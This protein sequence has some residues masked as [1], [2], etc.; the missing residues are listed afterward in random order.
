MKINEIKIIKEESDISDLLKKLEKE[1]GTDYSAEIRKY[2][3]DGNEK[4]D[5][6]PAEKPDEKPEEKDDIIWAGR[7]WSEG[8]RGLSNDSDPKWQELD[9]GVLVDGS[10]LTYNPKRPSDTKMPN[11]IGNRVLDA[12]EEQT[13]QTITYWIDFYYKKMNS[14]PNYGTANKK[15]SAFVARIL[16]INNFSSSRPKIKPSSYRD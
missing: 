14:Q 4:P 15:F 12:I 16:M 6:K 13:G 10:V 8:I 1:T 3:N 2:S 9:L 11:S 5:E 7:N